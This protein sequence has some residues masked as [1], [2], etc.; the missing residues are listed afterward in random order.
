MHE[1]LARADHLVTEQNEPD[2]HV[3]EA[4]AE[5][6]A[7]AWKE[8]NQQLQMRGFLLSETLRFYNLVKKHENVSVL[9][10][11]AY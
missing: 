5:S 9:Y 7:M 1:L 3:Y 2:V 10:C 8:L 6:L 4:M 11:A